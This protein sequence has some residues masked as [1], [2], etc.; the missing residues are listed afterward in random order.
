MN[1]NLLEE[2]ESTIMSYLEEMDSVEPGENNIFR[3]E[4]SKGELESKIWQCFRK[5]EAVEYHHK[6]IRSI[7][8]FT[9]EGIE[10]FRNR[11]I[12]LVGNRTLKKRISIENH[13]VLFEIDAFLAAARSALD[14]LGAVLSRYIEGTDT[15]RLRVIASLLKHSKG[16]LADFIANEWIDWIEDFIDYRDDLLHRTVIPATSSVFSQVSGPDAK[17]NKLKKVQAEY[18]EGMEEEVIAV[19]PIPLKPNLASRLS[20][21]EVFGPDDDDPPLGFLKSESSLI[22]EDGSDKFQLTSIKYEVEHGFIEA[23][24]F[25]QE[26]L[27]KIVNFIKTVFDELIELNFAHIN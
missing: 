21:F 3:A 1:Q 25:S 16:A 2:L 23:E 22:I 27:E 17:T 7:S 6:R 12:E 24:K 20:R 15:D 19:C 9:R 5:L 13:D 26:N 11:K 18:Q 4:R 14:F 8:D 10:S